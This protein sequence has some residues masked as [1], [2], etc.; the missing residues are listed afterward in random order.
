MRSILLNTFKRRGKSTG[1]TGFW[2]KCLKENWG[3][4]LSFTIDGF[5]TIAMSL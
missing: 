3:V 2:P 5:Q 1:Q 4:A